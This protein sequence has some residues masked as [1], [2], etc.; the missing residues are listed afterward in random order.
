M[1][2][3]PY[4]SAWK[5]RLANQ[6]R[7]TSLGARVARL[8][9]PLVGAALLVPLVRPVFLHFLDGPP[10]E[11]APGMQGV[12]VRV[13]LVLVS[14][15]S[16]DLYSALV[17]G[18][19]RAVLDL[20]PVDPA[21]VATYQVRRVLVTR[22]WL[23][24]L[25]LLLLGPVAWEGQPLA[26][27]LGAV[28]T[29][30]SFA[31]GLSTSAMVHLL[32]I[33]ASRSERLAPLLDMVR[34]S[35]PRPQAAFIYAPGVVLAVDGG[36][37]ALSSKGVAMALQGSVLVGGLALAVPFVVAALAWL[38]VRGLARRSWFQASAVIADI[39][40]RYGALVDR[41]EGH[42]VYLDWSARFLPSTWAV[43]FLKDLRHGWRGRR[44]WITGA[45]LVGV[46]GV[47]A[48][49]TS[50]PSS[51]WRA[52]AVGGAGALVCA[53]LG[54]VLEQDEPE[55]LRAWLPPGGLPRQ[56]ARLLVLVAWLQAA[57][58]PGPI[59]VAIRHGLGAGASALVAGEVVVLGAAVLAWACGL[60]RERG[61]VV[62]APTA[63]VT[64]GAVA[65]WA[66]G[67]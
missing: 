17:R 57:V 43:Y 59:S 25:A 36:L 51:P 56:G 21:Q 19:D 55:L 10:A 49:W 58:L 31:L 29:L 48:G 7:V 24:G 27:A 61:L 23:P 60:I 46:G 1:A 5:T 6:R 50:D 66:L 11:L 41:D 64:A 15:L 42:R 28:A 14:A 47:L 26:W 9:V 12:L 33:G 4:I 54:V 45:W 62:Y 40:A 30:G 20:L 63:A 53:S 3:N 39:D 2:G 16:L 18:G 44:T 37:V 38:P 65:L 8:L 67:G 35:N 52:A 22:W 32:A 13:G 34:G